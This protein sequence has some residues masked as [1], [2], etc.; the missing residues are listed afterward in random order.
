M[1][2]DH[3]IS[4]EGRLAAELH[5]QQANNFQLVRTL[6][7]SRM[8]RASDPGSR[9]ELSAVLQSVNALGRMQAHLERGA[10]EVDFAGYLIDAAGEWRADAHG[11]RIDVVLDLRSV[12]LS[13]STASALALIADELVG[14]SLRHAFAPTGPGRVEVS[15]MTNGGRAALGV[16]DTGCGMGDG[17]PGGGLKLVRMLARRAGGDLALRDGRGLMAVVDFPAV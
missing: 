17:L 6:I 2:A 15:L 9:R 12:R 13:E 11:R 14:N 5:H 16:A 7:S 1:L 10:G 4:A 3:A 8:R